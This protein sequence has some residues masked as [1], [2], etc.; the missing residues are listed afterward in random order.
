MHPAGQCE[1]MPDDI[2]T[3]CV[4]EDD[5]WEAL[6]LE[7][8]AERAVAASLTWHGIGGEVVVMGCDDARIAA[9]NADFR[10]KPRPTN[11]LSWPSVEHSA[12]DPGARPVPPDTDELGDIAISYDTCLAEA[13]AQ[14]KPVTDHV[15]HLL[16]HATLH[17]LGYD[18]LNDADA[19]TMET[20]E[21]SILAHLNIPDPYDEKVR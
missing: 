21:R 9:L 14:G 4:I 15:T 2:S 1:A 8:L 19:E 3:D 16:V 18:H 17:L 12:R 11:V 5:R 7:T 10:G 13:E 20:T 6:G